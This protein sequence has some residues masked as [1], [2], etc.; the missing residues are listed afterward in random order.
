MLTDKRGVGSD[1]D[2][3]AQ[4][5]LLR[6]EIGS[7]AGR[8]GQR[9]ALDLETRSLGHTATCLLQGANAG[10]F[11]L[12]TS[13]VVHECGTRLPQQARTGFL[14]AKWGKHAG[15]HTLSTPCR[16]EAGD[17]LP[18][19][20]IGAKASLSE[21]SSSPRDYTVLILGCDGRVITGSLGRGYGTLERHTCFERHWGGHL[22]R[23][24][25]GGPN[26]SV[27]MESKDS[28]Y[29]VSVIASVS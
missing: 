26:G 10:R 23:E 17:I 24:A 8:V 27:L 3:A 21:S 4:A 19:P 11:P 7:Q 15:L 12:L 20:E 1:Q 22:P 28:S 5:E 6:L 13:A 14:P 29:P 2:A 25:G 18:E 9:S 16:W